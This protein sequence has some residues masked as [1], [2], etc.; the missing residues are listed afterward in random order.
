MTSPRPQ[1][2]VQRLLFKVMLG[3]MAFS[4]FLIASPEASIRLDLELHGIPATMQRAAATAPAPTSWM[5]DQGTS[6]ADFPVRL[7]S[8]DG[9][10]KATN[11]FLPEHVVRSLLAGETA[12]ITVVWDTPRRFVLEG[13]PA[14]P[15]GGGWIALGLALSATFLF[16]L[17]L[18]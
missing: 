4:C 3:A 16:A 17:R 8:R 5:E 18:R 10:T 7:T 14:P 12:N 9:A 11:L 13:E 15:I 6:R 2:L 1:Q